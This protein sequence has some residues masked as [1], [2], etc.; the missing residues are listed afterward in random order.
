M[1]AGPV[2]IGTKTIKTVV[3]IPGLMNIDVPI[4]CDREK[5]ITKVAPKPIVM[6]IMVG[7]IMTIVQ[8]VPVLVGGIM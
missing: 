5:L 8:T 2:I 7:K 3:Q 1:I 6:T 4:V